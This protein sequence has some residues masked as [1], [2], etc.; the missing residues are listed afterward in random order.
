MLAHIQDYY[1][2]PI[3]AGN[4]QLEN[5]GVSILILYHF[6]QEQPSRNRRWLFLYMRRAGLLLNYFLYFNTCAICNPHKV[7]TIGQ[8]GYIDFGL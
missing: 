8:G 6:I 3:I 4:Y 7:N 1:A 2:G 5:A